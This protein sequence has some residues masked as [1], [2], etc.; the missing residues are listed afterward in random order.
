MERSSLWTI[1]FDH[2]KL[3]DHLKY[4]YIYSFLSFANYSQKYFSLQINIILVTLCFVITNQA[5][6]FLKF[7]VDIYGKFSE[8]NMEIFK[9]L[10][11]LL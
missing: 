6:N 10:V 2:S 7:R 4:L 9:L 11:K 8:I 3:K 1:H 5:K